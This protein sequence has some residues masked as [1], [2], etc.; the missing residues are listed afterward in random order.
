MQLSAAAL[1]VHAE[2]GPE[3]AYVATPYSYA[4]FAFISSLLAKV[5]SAWLALFRKKAASMARPVAIL[6][7]TSAAGLLEVAAYGINHHALH[8]RYSYC[9]AEKRVILR[10]RSSQNQIRP[11][12]CFA[13]SKNIDTEHAGMARTHIALVLICRGLQPGGVSRVEHRVVSNAG[14]DGSVLRQIVSGSILDDHGIE[15]VGQE[16]AWNCACAQ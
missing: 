4:R 13:A 15:R 7:A 2:S 14:D 9:L 1:A 6:P 16:P 10:S 3:T 8:G 11:I 5:V 12:R